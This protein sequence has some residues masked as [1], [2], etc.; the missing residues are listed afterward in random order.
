[1]WQRF[2][3]H[4]RQ[5]IVYAQEEAAKRHEHFLDTEHLLLGILRETESVTR[6]VLEQSGMSVPRL[7]SELEECISSDGGSTKAEFQLARGAKRAIDLAYDEARR[8]RHGSIEPGHLLLGL[9][10]VEEGLAGQVLSKRDVN[11]DKLRDAVSNCYPEVPP[12]PSPQLFFRQV[13]RQFTRKEP[14]SEP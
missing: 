9:I 4:T 11:L 10:R 1:M 14:P 5:T 3:N 13:I 12:I 8:L 2:S 7:L 6:Q